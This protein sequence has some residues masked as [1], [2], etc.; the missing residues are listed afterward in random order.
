MELEE[1]IERFLPN[2]CERLNDFKKGKETDPPDYVINVLF[3]PEALQ[4]FADKICEKQR[5]NCLGACPVE[6]DKRYCNDVQNAE[7][8]KIDEI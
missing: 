8:P 1:F 5:E 4:N 2:Y 6:M 3:F 7:Q